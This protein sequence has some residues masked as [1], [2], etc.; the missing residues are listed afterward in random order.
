MITAALVFALV[1]G[2]AYVVSREAI[3]EQA[4]QNGEVLAQATANRNSAQFLATAKVTDTACQ[5]A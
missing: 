5:L 3:V 2:Y 1:V 4:R